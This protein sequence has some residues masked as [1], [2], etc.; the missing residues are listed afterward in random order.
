MGVAVTIYIRKADEELWQR[1]QAYAKSRGWSMSKLI[2]Q[3]LRRRLRN[4]R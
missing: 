2:E 4:E 3:A 1:Y